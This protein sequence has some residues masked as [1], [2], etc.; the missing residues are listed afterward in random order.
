MNPFRKVPPSQPKLADNIEA[1]EAR[2]KALRI[3]LG[4]HGLRSSELARL[5]GLPSAN[6]LYNY[7]NG[8]SR[9]L[10]TATWALLLPHLP[11][12]DPKVLMGL[13]EHTATPYENDNYLANAGT[14]FTDEQKF[15]IQLVVVHLIELKDDLRH[16]QQRINEQTLGIEG[17]ERWLTSLTDQ[18]PSKI[19][20][21]LKAMGRRKQRPTIFNA[22]GAVPERFWEPRCLTSRFSMC[23]LDISEISL[24]DHQ[25]SS[26]GVG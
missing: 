6:G 9:N 16:L 14:M 5:A 10:E 24:G 17:L 7:L 23:L 26:R 18:L 3:A 8:R 2:R 20:R 22:D 12:S 11:K 4:E 1:I 21:R 25:K 13:I 19:R 15:T